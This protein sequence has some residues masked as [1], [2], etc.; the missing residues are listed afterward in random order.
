MLI[1]YFIFHLILAYSFLSSQVA[2][3]EQDTREKVKHLK[4][5]LPQNME[6]F[7]IWGLHQICTAKLPAVGHQFRFWAL[8]RTGKQYSSLDLNPFSFSNWNVLN[9]GSITWI[10]DII[11]KK[12]E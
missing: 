3:S 7:Y 6:I 11:K 4:I 5:S 12:K 2:G 9:H 8:Q 1:W 10:L